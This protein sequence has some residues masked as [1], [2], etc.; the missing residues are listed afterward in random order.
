MRISH[1]N[2]PSD[3]VSLAR[4]LLGK[5]LMRSIDGMMPPAELWT[6]AIAA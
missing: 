1:K 6:E 5:V 2:V 3:T 4:A